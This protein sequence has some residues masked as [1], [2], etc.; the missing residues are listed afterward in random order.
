ML[1]GR[2]KSIFLNSQHNHLVHC[3]KRRL[4]YTIFFSRI[5][6]VLFE[7]MNFIVKSLS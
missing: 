6:I 4:G 5:N 1:K 7:L 3:E 2:G